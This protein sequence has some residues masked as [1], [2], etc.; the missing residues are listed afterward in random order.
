[1]NSFRTELDLRRSLKD[2]GLSA[3]ADRIVATVRPALL[4]VRRQRPD[5]ALPPGTSK[6]G[7][8]PDLPAG[9]A[10]P[11][12]PPR[13]DAA[14][15][16]HALRERRA[17]QRAR[18]ASSRSTG[19][20]DEILSLL[21]E[22]EREAWLRSMEASRPDQERITAQQTEQDHYDE[23]MVASFNRHF[24]LAFLAQLDLGALSREP[25]FDADLPTHGLL[26]LFEDLTDQDGDGGAQLHWFD[27]PTKTLQRR[28]PPDELIA[29]SDARQPDF[30]WHEQTMAETLEPHSTLIVPFHWAEAAG[31]H[32]AAM[33]SFLHRPANGHF[34]LADHVDG[35]QAGSFG[36][37][38]GGWP[39]PIQTDPELWFIGD[40]YGRIEPGDD[41]IR[42]LF[43]WGGEYYAETRRMHAPFGGDGRIY[44]MIRRE[45][46]IARRFDKARA[47]YQ[48]D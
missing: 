3:L 37:R 36:D 8:L 21:P 22:D 11:Q 7:G 38:L 4:F 34:P 16:A 13:Q 35:E 43:S 19:I 28:S 42:H 18:L 24:P 14:A 12:R 6:M 26:S 5:D 46:L 23:L 40:E 9:I 1:M 29:L 2:A 44:L 27:Q 41:R 33:F 48:C 47:L 20:D 45:D 31:M 32:R 17:Q 10:W 39:D 25:G 30:P 15:L